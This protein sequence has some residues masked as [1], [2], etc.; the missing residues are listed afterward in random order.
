MNM[1]NVNIVDQLR[2]DYRPDRWMRKQKWWW[3]MFFRGYRVN[4]YVAYK[5]HMEMEGEVPMSQYDF[6]KEIVL[7]KV[8][9]LGHGTPTPPIECLS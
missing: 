3:L 4:A 2:G 6:R 1:N 5:Q 7:A 8:D 9:P